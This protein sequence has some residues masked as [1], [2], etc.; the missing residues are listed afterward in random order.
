MASPKYKVALHIYDLRPERDAPG[1]EAPDS[2]RRLAIGDPDPHAATSRATPFCLRF[3]PDNPALIFN[4][5]MDIEEFKDTSPPRLREI[6]ALLNRLN[7]SQNGEPNRLA[8]LWPVPPEGAVDSS[9]RNA[10]ADLSS[11]E[12]QRQGAQK[13]RENGVEINKERGEKTRARIADFIVKK[14][15]KSTDRGLA[16]RIAAALKIDR[17]TAARYLKAINKLK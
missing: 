14:N 7:G 12:R 11:D 16:A 13:G 6:S 8:I 15:A 3:V 9:T 2:T 5:V 1:P 4:G 10:N 17:S